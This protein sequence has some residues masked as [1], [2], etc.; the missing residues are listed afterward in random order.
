MAGAAAT[1]PARHAATRRRAATMRAAFQASAI[2]AAYM[3]T[4]RALRGVHTSHG[5]IRERRRVEWQQV[6][7]VTK[8]AND[9][10]RRDIAP[11]ALIAPARSHDVIVFDYAP[12]RRCL[13]ARAIRL[14]RREPL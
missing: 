12:T 1:P 5:E 11:V 2:R 4:R 14:Q 3:P 9:G 13:K 10:E 8:R 6:V 7:T